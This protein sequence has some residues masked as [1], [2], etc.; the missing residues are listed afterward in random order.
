[1][2]GSLRRVLSR[3]LTARGLRVFMWAAVAVWLAV[4]LIVIADVV[5]IPQISD[6]RVY[7]RLAEDCAD[8]GVW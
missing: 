1:M 7:Q 3:V 8:R 5:D 4:Q 6:A 2:A